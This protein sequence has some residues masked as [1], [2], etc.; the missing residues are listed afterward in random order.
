MKQNKFD[1]QKV[2]NSM[3]EERFVEALSSLEF[4]LA[5]Q[6]NHFECL[7]LAA[8]CS[9][10]LKNFK[11]AQ[12]YLERLLKVNPDMGRAYQE[13]GHLNRINGKMRSA[14]AYY[15]QACELNPALIASWNYLF[16]YYKKNKNKQAADHAVEQIKKLQSIPNIL[17]YISQILN[18]GKLAIAEEKCREFLKKNPTNTYATVSYTHLTLPTKA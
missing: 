3:K 7:Y 12:S 5:S 6:P 4:N 17:L 18:E 8:V 16:E 9:R 10:Y 15:R 14:M 2:T 11:D 13:L 1:L